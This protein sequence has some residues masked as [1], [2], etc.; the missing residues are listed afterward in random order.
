MHLTV[1]TGLSG[2][3]KTIAMHT[4][5]D[6]GFYCVDNLPARL[7]SAFADE[8]RNLSESDQFRAAVSVDARSPHNSLDE[9]PAI[10]QSLI[11]RRI[12]SQVIFLEANQEA[13]LKRF[14]ET[15]RRHP[16]TGSQTNLAG[17]LKRERDLLAPVRDLADIRID[18]SNLHLHQLREAIRARIGGDDANRAALTFESFGYKNGI[19]DDADFV[20]DARCL[21][22]P[23]WEPALRALT[24]KDTEVAKFL[25]AQSV[26]TQYLDSLR[27][28][29][30]RWLVNFTADGRS[31]LTIA[32]GCTGG[33]HRSVHVVEHLAELFRSRHEH[34]LVRHRD[35]DEIG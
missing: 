27:E 5:E 34:V 2:A 1:V 20:F 17:A 3:G 33:Q 25:Q 19:P 26:T 7:L 13:L 4:L 18:T 23:Y 12:V 16:L 10:L 9:F 6:M 21:P 30:D 14:S 11:T 15:R 32:I 22:N 31:Y 24:G 28:F 29:L 35:L 8:L